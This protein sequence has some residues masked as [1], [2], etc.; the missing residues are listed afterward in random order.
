MGLGQFAGEACGDLGRA[1]LTVV[2]VSYVEESE[3]K[4]LLLGISQHLTELGVDSEIF[5]VM[6][7]LR[8]ADG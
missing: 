5:E 7:D 3:P 8:H 1:D 6:C 2:G 4:Q